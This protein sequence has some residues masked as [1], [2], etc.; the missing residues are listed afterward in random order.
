M[1]LNT[2]FERFV[3][4]SPI[5]VM[6]RGILERVLSDDKLDELFEKTAQAG[7]TRELLFSTLVKMM[8]VVVCN[9]HP[10]L[11]ATYK[12]MAG[13]I[14][15]SRTAMYDKIN[16]IEPQVSAALI[17]YTANELGPIIHQ[18]KG[19]LPALLPGWRT[20]IL[21][22]NHLGTTE[23]RLKVLARNGAAPLPGKSLV[24]LDPLFMLA[25][26]VF[27]CEDGHAQERSL[28]NQVLATVGPKD[29]YIADRNMCTLP[30]L[31]GLNEKQAAFIIREHKGMPWQALEELRPLGRVDTGELFEQ[32]VML[33]Y[34]GQEL[35]VRRIFLKLDKPTRDGETEIALF[36]NLPE[37]INTSIVADLYRKRWKVETAFQVVTETFKCE[38]KTLGYP[39]A[40]LFSFCMALVAYNVLSC[41]KAALRSVHGTGKIEAGISNYY[42]AEEVE[43]TYRGMMIAI[44]AIHWQIF[45]QMTISEF[46]KTLNY[47]AN[48]VRLERFSSSVRGPKKPKPKPTYDPAHPHV[49]TAKLLAEAKRK[50]SP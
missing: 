2:I 20:L 43:G 40:A 25:I 3:Q 15:V 26:R 37:E 46:S 49:S 27:P 39:R 18:L 41:V 19:T 32:L 12:A 28:F 23:R 6:V 42:L 16:R 47:L 14:G 17:E 1:W 13:E 10:S 33:S 11:S 29:L 9:I 34:Q 7:Y 5:T 36:T 21:D 31:F 22:G 45:Q 44:P 50:K 24:V 38:I 8:T 30:F 35:R 4:D 48:Q